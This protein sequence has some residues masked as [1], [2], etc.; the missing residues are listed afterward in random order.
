M[1][2]ELRAVQNIGG[3][4]MDY[5]LIQGDC[6]DVLPTLEDES[7]DLIMTDPPYAREYVPL[8]GFL[9]EEGARVLKEGHYL[10]A[11]CGTECLPDVLSLMTPHLD[12][13]YLFVVEHRNSAPRLW[14]KHIMVG[15]KVVLA[16]TKGKPERL[17]WMNNIHRSERRDKRFHE[18]GQSEGFPAKIIEMLTDKGDLVLDPFLGGGTTMKVCQMTGRSCIGIEVDPDA[19]KGSITERCFWDSM[20]GE[21][22][23]VEHLVHGGDG[24]RTVMKRVDGEGR[25]WP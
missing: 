12:W 9:A 18:W 8:Y 17:R 3:E 21:E 2:S 10:F 24:M 4:R 23:A 6:R 20:L 5:K 22:Y 14:Y 16:F 1:G 11:Y 19:C 15:C 7:I 25:W 13:F